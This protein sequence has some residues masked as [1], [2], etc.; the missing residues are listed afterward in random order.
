MSGESV[1]FAEQCL[2]DRRSI[3]IGF[4]VS[5]QYASA[6]GYKVIEAYKKIDRALQGEALRVKIDS[7]L[8]VCEK[9]SLYLAKEQIA[10]EYASK[11]SYLGRLKMAIKY[12]KIAVE[13]GKQS[14]GKT[15]NLDGALLML[16]RYYYNNQQYNKGIQFYEKALKIDKRPYITASAYAELGNSYRQI[17]DYYRSKD[18]FDKALKIFEDNGD[19]INWL[20]QSINLA[21]TYE[22]IDTKESLSNRFDLLL[23]ADSLLSSV[24]LNTYNY[25]LLKNSIANQYTRESYYNFEKS[26]DIYFDNIKRGQSNT[27][28]TTL[29]MTYTNLA[30]LYNLE[31]KDSAKYWANKGL[32]IVTLDSDRAR[33]Y[34]NLSD[35]Y[36]IMNGFKEALENIHMAMQISLESEMPI[37]QAPTELQLHNAIAKDYIMYCLRQKC[38]VLNKLYLETG[39]EQFINSIIDHVHAGDLLGQMISG[40]STSINSKLLW[41]KEASS[42]YHL[43]TEAAKVLGDDATAFSFT[44][45]N[46]AI[47]LA[48]EI[49][50]NTLNASLPY[51]LS[52]RD[53]ALKGKIL[54]LE[55][56]NSN[57]DELFNAKQEYN[58][59][60]DSINL[61]YPEFAAQQ[62]NIK[63]QNLDEVQGS[64]KRGQLLVSY[65]WNRPNFSKEKIIGLAIDK[66][67]VKTFEIEA[68]EQWNQQIDQFRDLVSRPLLTGEDLSTFRTLSSKLYQALLPAHIREGKYPGELLIVP[69][70]ALQNLPF[71][72]LVVDGEGQYL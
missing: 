36:M 16:G 10:F 46:K 55:A 45:K 41:R 44:E 8:A 62:T 66:N 58:Q 17:G 47:L 67:A 31:K 42:L 21:W 33:L 26:R 54:E 5:V 28:T 40:R 70:G 59:L 2:L 9:D 7:L 1:S 35:Y 72:A 60:K 13:A 48:E 69:D 15:G 27:D 22:E 12:G 25:N 6:Q 14:N 39:N 49:A 29:S 18:Y 11:S 50:E 19:R 34:D 65:I 20:I 68:D 64:L 52:L 37:A 32:E 4:I 23:K 57:S 53:K 71:E 63:I 24:E 51:H 61:L 56:S 38:E 30:Y 43:G 3:L